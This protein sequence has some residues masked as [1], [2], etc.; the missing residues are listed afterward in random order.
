MIDIRTSDDLTNDQHYIHR[1]VTIAI[2]KVT[3]IIFL[4]EVT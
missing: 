3:L 2:E 1:Y 4:Y